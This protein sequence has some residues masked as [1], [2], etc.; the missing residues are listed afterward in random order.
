M[1]DLSKKFSQNAPGGLYVDST[2]IDCETCRWMAPDTF[3]ESSGHSIVYQQ[4]ETEQQKIRAHQALISC[5]SGSIGSEDSESVKRAAK[6]F[7]SPLEEDV[8]HCG[9]HSEKSFGAASY[10]IRRSSGNI[11]I[12]SPRFAAPLVRRIEEMGGIRT[13]I[14]THR[15][16]IADQKQF[17]EHFN[18]D[19]V[20]HR[21]DLGHPLRNVE[22]ELS[23]ENPIELE[24]DITILPVPGHTKGHIVIHF[25]KKFLFT[26]DHLAFWPPRSSLIAFRNACWYSWTEQTKSM[27]ILFGIEFEW[28]LPGHGFPHHSSN[29]EIRAQLE[30]LVE[31]METL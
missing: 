12:D 22:I 26:G 21:D 29:E 19:R 8:F 24:N 4:P 16:D 13:M 20:M 23:G 7:P 3:K 25:K 27:R 10:F 18:C 14:L 15:D 5:P 30:R 1:A 28:V 31:R 6:S 2:C 17:Q 11:L 9:Y